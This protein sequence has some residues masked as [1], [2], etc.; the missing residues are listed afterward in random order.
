MPTGPSAHE[1]VRPGRLPVAP[2]HPPS[3]PVPSSRAFRELQRVVFGVGI[4]RTTQG[5]KLV[6]A[7]DLALNR[8]RLPTK[9]LVKKV[10][11]S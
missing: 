2:P 10:K 3:R 8:A 1:E 11:M 7:S 9:E 5:L 4:A 6:T